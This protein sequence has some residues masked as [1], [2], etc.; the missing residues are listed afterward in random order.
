[1]KVEQMI[2]TFKD[3]SENITD[4]L[5]TTSC[6]I[7]YLNIYN[8]D[9]MDTIN[10]SSLRRDD[11]TYP[12]YSLLLFRK[13]K[14]KLKFTEIDEEGD[15]IPGDMDCEIGR[16]PYS[17]GQ[18][19]MIIKF[20]TNVLFTNK[21]EPLIK[22][23][24]VISALEI[25]QKILRKKISHSQSTMI[26]YIVIGLEEE[27]KLLNISP[28]D[29]KYWLADIS[30]SVEK[31]DNKSGEYYIQSYCHLADIT[32]DDKTNVVFYLGHK[33]KSIKINYTDLISLIQPLLEHHGVSYNDIT[34]DG[35]F[36]KIKN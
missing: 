11:D 22:K 5:L 20:N 4:V 21:I 34:F 12:S 6:E 10:E 13:I 35:H 8:D 30:K 19:K 26:D 27:E 1:M 14:F 3:V 32:T 31:S 36:V 18:Y 29:L 16:Y 23:D 28:Q 25:L 2:K 7:E 15:E 33:E 24:V 9:F 17:V